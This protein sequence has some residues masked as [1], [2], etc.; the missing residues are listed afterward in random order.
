MNKIDVNYSITNHVISIRTCGRK[1]LVDIFDQLKTGVY[2][3]KRFSALTYKI[4]NP[5]STIIFFSTGN[6]TLMGSPSYYGAL[7]ILNYIKNKLDLEFVNVKLTNIVS[8][9]SIKDLFFKPL[10]VHSF[11]IKNSDRSISNMVIFPCCSYKLP[12]KK[13]KINIFK[14]GSMVVTGCKNKDVVEESIYYIL[15]EINSF[16]SEDNDIKIQAITE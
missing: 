7:Y 1:S 6:I 3:P 15:N 16:I 4:T 13:I 10:H 5:K 9:F 2:K 14:T 8:C 11:F 12:D